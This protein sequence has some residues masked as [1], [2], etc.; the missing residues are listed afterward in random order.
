MVVNQGNV[1]CPVGRHCWSL[2]AYYLMGY[3][4]QMKASLN[5][6]REIDLI[7]IWWGPKDPS[8]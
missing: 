4:H 2:A 1:M 6:R 8:P 3:S 5:N 7:H